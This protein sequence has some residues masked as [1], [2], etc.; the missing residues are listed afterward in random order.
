M[1]R[2]SKI[3]PRLMFGVT[4]A[5]LLPALNIA[6]QTKQ[7]QQTNQ[8]MVTLKAYKDPPVEISAVKVK[9]VPIAPKHKF[10]M[11][12]DWL[13]HI[14]ITAKNVYDKPIAYLSVLI[15]APYEKD[16]KRI[17]A[18]VELRY[19]AAPANTGDPSPPYTPPLLPGESVV[20]EFN[21][22]LRDELRSILISE[23]ASTDVEEVS[24]RVYEVFFQGDG[25]TK[26][27]TG[28]MLRR[29]SNDSRLWIPIEPNKPIGRTFRK[30]K[31]IPVRFTV[32]IRP[33][34]DGEVN[35]CTYKYK[36][37][38]WTAHQHTEVSHQRMV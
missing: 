21:E 4:L 36:G 32:P 25:N 28:G 26:W 3:L 17:L 8:R 11:E 14:T 24:I 18:V 9:G 22:R 15:G 31:L 1:F 16:G 37:T 38:R 23:N 6:Q 35:R 20:L 27:S 10:T 5:L 7:P 19:G 33:I 29:D 2:E 30:P 13:N 12:S 34:V